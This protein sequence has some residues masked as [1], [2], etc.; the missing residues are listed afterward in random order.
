MDRTD[1]PGRT[2]FDQAVRELEAT[3][4]RKV[5]AD[6][7]AYGGRRSGARNL[8]S[9]VAIT[10]IVLSALLPLLASFDYAGKQ[11]IVSSV[12]VII[13]AMTGLGS[14]FHWGDLWKGYLVA[15]N[16]IQNARAHW[17]LDIIAARREKTEEAA[18]QRAYEAADRLLDTTRDAI[19]REQGLYFSVFGKA[20]MDKV[21]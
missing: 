10:T 1:H 5:D 11:L 9:L 7:R 19:R 6:M 2:Q 16:D 3:V 18:L 12:G 21:G 17:E 13:A 15:W 20:R 8:A 14:Y 4:I